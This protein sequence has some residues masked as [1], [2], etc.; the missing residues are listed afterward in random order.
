MINIYLDKQQSALNYL[1]DIEININNVLIITSN[2]NIST[3][4]I[5]L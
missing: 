1:K 5:R 4:T 3:H 2:F